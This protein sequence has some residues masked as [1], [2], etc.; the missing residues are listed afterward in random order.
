MPDRARDLS[1]LT[2]SELD[3]AKRDLAVSSALAWPGSL[4]LVPIT[5][6]MQA[7]D[8]ELARRAESS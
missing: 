8:A 5:A 1:R 7:I 6:E 2:A 4:A 3:Q